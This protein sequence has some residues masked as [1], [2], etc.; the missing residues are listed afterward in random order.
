MKRVKHQK[1]RQRSACL[2]RQKTNRQTERAPRMRRLLMEMGLPSAVGVLLAMLVVLALTACGNHSSSV[3]R[4][5]DHSFSVHVGAPKRGPYP[6]GAKG[7]RLDALAV[8]PRNPQTLFAIPAACKFDKSMD[9]GATWRDL[10]LGSVFV[11]D[12]PDCVS[13]LA[14]A[15]N[16]VLYVDTDYNS[17]LKSTDGGATWQRLGLT[18]PVRYAL[19][20]DPARPDSVFV[21]AGNAP[22]SRHGGGVYESTVGGGTWRRLG[23]EDQEVVALAVAP[24]ARIIYVGTANVGNSKSTRLGIFK[25]ADGGKSWRQVGIRH[26]QVDGLWLDPRSANVVYA[27]LNY[28]GCS[29]S[30]CTYN[31]FRSRDGGVTWKKVGPNSDVFTLA[32]DPRHPHVIYAG[33][34]GAAATHKGLFR[35]ADGGTSW[36]RIGPNGLNVTGLA[37]TSSGDRLYASTEQG[38]VYAIRVG[39]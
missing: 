30:S 1:T 39:G 11:N 7:L 4:R 31:L 35:S 14:F 10:G 24:G 18:R 28:T 2:V 16:S 26:A 36:R 29:M 32:L 33:A 20:V 13:G 27:D 34:G 22:S 37:I 17:V 6:P 9:G 19:A 3:S 15:S 5:D 21:A 23:L 38:A 8:D 25:S 12:S